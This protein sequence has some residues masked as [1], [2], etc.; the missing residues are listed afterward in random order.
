M[1]YVIMAVI[2][3]AVGW[4]LKQADRIKL[5]MIW[6][7]ALGAAGGLVGGF[8]ATLLSA[9]AV[10]LFKLLLAAIGAYFAV[11]FVQRFRD[12]RPQ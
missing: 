1:M 12:G 8:I 3:A 2:G 11:Y 7:I 10:V 6:S 5:D 9:F 4:Y